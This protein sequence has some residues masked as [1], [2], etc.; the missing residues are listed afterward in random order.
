MKVDLI[1]TVSRLVMA[2]D[3]IQSW[4]NLLALIRY[5]ITVG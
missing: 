1:L 5:S 3:N 4:E 2:E